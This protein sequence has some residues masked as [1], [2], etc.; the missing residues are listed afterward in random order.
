MAT[1]KTS[2]GLC[3]VA[4]ML[5][6]GILA[7]FPAQGALIFEGAGTGSLSDLHAEATFEITT[8]GTLEITLANTSMADVWD[9]NFIL[10][11]L[12]FDVSGPS[13]AMTPLSAAVAAGSKVIFPRATDMSGTPITGGT[14]PGGDISAEW[15]FRSD[16]VGAPHDATHGVSAAWLFLFDVSNLFDPTHNLQGPTG[17]RG[18]QYGLTSAG[19][20]PLTGKVDYQ[21]IGDHRVTGRNALVQNAVVLTFGVAD[22]FSLGSIDNVN[23][24]YGIRPYHPNVVGQPV[25][26]EPATLLLLS[27]SVAA[28]ALRRFRRRS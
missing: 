6:A 19:D 13:T 21:T 12:F 1:G 5:L 15:A 18:L 17:P 24:Q 26:P 16:L 10:T 14:Y 7:A 11:A 23:F 4:A 22:D 28:L 9:P 2:A 25:V 3:V 27:G 20:D 8:P